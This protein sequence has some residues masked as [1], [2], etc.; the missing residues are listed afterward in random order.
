[1]MK[2]T[3]ALLGIFTST[4]AIAS[5]GPGEIKCG[6]QLVEVVK[7]KDEIK[8]VNVGESMFG[9]P[10]MMGPMKLDGR[11]RST[12][13]TFVGHRGISIQ[14]QGTPERVSVNLRVNKGGGREEDRVTLYTNEIESRAGLFTSIYVP[15]DQLLI[16]N[17][18]NSSKIERI[19]L[20]CLPVY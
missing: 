9:L 1:M 2:R 4:L 13:E 16:E 8:Q 17:G 5:E 20:S 14:I 12:G 18:R 15:V 6:Y 7:H 10:S 3:L 19:I 11:I